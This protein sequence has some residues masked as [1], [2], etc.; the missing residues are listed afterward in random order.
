MNDTDVRSNTRKRAAVA[1]EY[2]RK[3]K[4]RCDGRQPVCSL[5]QQSNRT[6]CH[7]VVNLPTQAEGETGTDATTTG[8]DSSLTNRLARLEAATEEHSASMDA[9]KKQLRELITT[10]N[11]SCTDG[12]LSY[13]PATT[14]QLTNPSPGGQTSTR[15]HDSVPM[16][17]PLGHGSTSEDLLRARK[18]KLLLG[19]H[20][21]NMF[22]KTEQKRGQ[23]EE[24]TLRLD[25]TWATASGASLEEAAAADLVNVYFAEVNSR[26]PV[27]DQETFSVIFN[28]TD[29]KGEMDT[30]VALVLMVLALASVSQETADNIKGNTL[31][32]AAFA[33]PSIQFLLR[34]WPSYYRTDTHLCQALF[35]AASWYNYLCRPLQAW[36]M[37]H[38][39]STNIQHAFLE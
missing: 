27:L 13:T 21:K 29:L 36:R 34:E 33:R 12:V 1:C 11:V 19:G 25:S 22:L 5:C 8:P 30:T 32:A 31:P 17:I 2:C 9:M 24:F 38:M 3:R 28:S 37:I 6:T 20:P 35:L 23:P 15:I 26:F 7:Y 39:A 10:A 16:T 14:V 4:R 18:V